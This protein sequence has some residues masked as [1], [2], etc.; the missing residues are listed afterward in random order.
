MHMPQGVGNGGYQCGSSNINLAM[1]NSMCVRFKLENMRERK[2]TRNGYV[3][4]NMA[5]TFKL[6]YKSKFIY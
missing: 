3:L 1:K 6:G 5:T 2:G 4:F